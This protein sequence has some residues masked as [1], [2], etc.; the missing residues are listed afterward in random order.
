MNWDAIGAIGETLGALAVI[1]TLIYFSIQI[2]QN[3]RMMHREAHLDRIRHVTDPLIGSP[4]NLSKVLEKIHA[5]DGSTEPVTLAFMEEY[6][7]KFEEAYSVLRYLHRLW[8]GYEADYLF[9]GRSVHLDKMI[10][11]MLTFPN[12]KLFWHHEK[13]WVFSPE[14][15]EYVDSIAERATS[16]Q[17]QKESAIEK[18]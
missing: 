5:K 18:G 8:I 9:T 2:R 17:N 15:V 1:A 16:V 12:N 3:T 7:L 10:P 4:E 11:L 14:F 6:D 13:K